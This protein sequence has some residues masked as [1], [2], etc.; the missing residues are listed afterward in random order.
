MTELTFSRVVIRPDYSKKRGPYGYPPRAYIPD[1][2]D[3]IPIKEQ[4]PVA[5]ALLRSEN[6][7]DGVA[8]PPAVQSAAQVEIERRW[9]D[10]RR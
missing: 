9:R 7:I 2:D 1:P 6:T 4:H 8:V 10:E 3:C 5:L